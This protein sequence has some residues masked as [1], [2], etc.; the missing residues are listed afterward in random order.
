VPTNALTLTSASGTTPSIPVSQTATPSPIS[1]PVNVG[2]IA[3]GAIGGVVL[4]GAIFAFAWYKIR[5]HGQVN[6][7]E[8]PVE[9]HPFS[10]PVE[11]TTDRYEQGVMEQGAIET[12]FESQTLRYPETSGN[13]REEMY[14]EAAVTKFYVRDIF[15]YIMRV[16]NLK[17]VQT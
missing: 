14:W 5:T 10:G 1:S 17:H 4:L 2:A 13:I 11:K 15:M 7:R 3:G 9:L 8:P 12:A 16:R 6:N